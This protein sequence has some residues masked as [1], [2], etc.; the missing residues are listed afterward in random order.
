VNA[1]R[2]RRL[3]TLSESSYD[4][5][6]KVGSSVADPDPYSFGPPGSGSVSADPAPDRDPSIIKQK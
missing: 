2:L 5:L 4:Q 6:L 3:A 1:G